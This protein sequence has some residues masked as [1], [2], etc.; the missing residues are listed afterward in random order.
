MGNGKL[1]VFEGVYGSGK[2]IVEVVNRL[3]EKLVSQGVEVYEID[4]PDTGR[5]RVM[6]AG[7]LD[8]SW[9]YGVFEADFFFELASRARVASVV[10]DELARGKTVLCKNFTLASVVHARL[11]GHDWVGEELN[12]LESRAR[13]IPFGRAVSPDLT[14]FVDVRPEVAERQLGG[15]LAEFFPPGTLDRQREYYLQELARLPAGR[16]KVI[17]AGSPDGVFE[18]SLDAIRALGP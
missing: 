9:R 6:G 2:L 8:T 7:E 17:A 10:R 18:E 13:G 3:R 1:V 15:R 4:S 14:I 11:A 16:A 5:A 12:V